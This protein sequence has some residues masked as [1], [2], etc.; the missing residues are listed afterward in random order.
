MS[1]IFRL[2]TILITGFS[3]TLAGIVSG[4]AATA[5]END[6]VRI[7]ASF[8]SG[9]SVLTKAQK[10]A[11]RQAVATSGVDATYQV[12]GV[13]GK[14]PGVSSKAVQSLAKK[15]AKAVRA[16]LLKLGIGKS[17][18]TSKIEVSEIGVVLK[19]SIIHTVAAPVASA[20]PT[21]AATAVL[22]TCATGGT[23]VVG[24]RGPGGGIVYYVSA[25]NFTSPGSTCAS[26]CKYLEVAPSTWKIG[27]PADD[28][29]YAWSS[30][31]TALT[32][33]VLT[34]LTG[35]SRESSFTSEQENWKIGRGFYNTSVMKATSAAKDAV[36]LYAGT[37]A[38]LGQWFVPSMNEL[39]ELC[40]YARGQSTGVL[41]EACSGSYN[42]KSGIVN[43]LGG[44]E[45]SFYWSSS[46]LDASNVMF[47]AFTNIALQVYA[48]K[49][50]QLNVRP[51]RAF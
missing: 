10:A 44:F 4:P 22:P 29:S 49:T 16:Y 24:D 11:I 26:A 42:L 38:S 28:E 3:L 9:S 36:L 19:N 20:T 45:G 50:A 14:L 47:Q 41:T 2:F 46:E 18:I 17:N 15:R 1:R 27:T 34:V 12:T 6:T 8:S 32:G 13:A 37:D 23:C 30:D 5:S 25:V 48:S 31:I 43:D 21:A 35:S 39:N 33:Q 51:I 40:K 7:S